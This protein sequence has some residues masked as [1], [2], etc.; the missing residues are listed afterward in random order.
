MSPANIFY[1][2]ILAGAFLAGQSENPVWVIL[3]IAAL[4]T[5]ARALDPAAA[6]TRAAQGKKL[7]RA[8]PLM[9]FN[10]II[11][12]N[13]VFLIGLGIFWALDAPVVAL[14][15]WLPILVSAVGLG[16]AIAVSRKG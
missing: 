14:P 5:V 4:A 7:A 3:V 13:L 8:L 9:V 10:Q 1:A 2:I 11:W 15:L 16:G 12:V 6:A